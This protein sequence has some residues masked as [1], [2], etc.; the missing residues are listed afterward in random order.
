MD[1][2]LLNRLAALERRV[3]DTRDASELSDDELLAII[4]EG[5]GRE[6]TEDD[7]KRIAAG[8]P[9]EGLKE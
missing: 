6:L 5:L 1:K 4:A 9:L 7:L 8:E 3:A 2:T